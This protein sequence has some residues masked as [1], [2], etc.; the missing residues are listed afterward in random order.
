MK[1]KKEGLRFLMKYLDKELV[2]GVLVVF[3][4]LKWYVAE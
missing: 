4:A 3:N 2:F 1:I